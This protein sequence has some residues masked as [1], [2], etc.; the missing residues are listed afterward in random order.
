MGTTPKGLPYPDPDGLVNDVDLVLRQLAEAVDGKLTGLVRAAGGRR[1]VSVS[2]ANT[3]YSATVNFPAGRFTAPPAVTVTPEI[4]G[5]LDST[6]AA[7]SAVTA[8]GFTLRWR[9]SVTT[10]F[11][12]AW[13][14]VAVG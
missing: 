14:A 10:D 9:R 7:V 8:D 13:T 11:D 4:T 5:Y 12:V 3:N 2:A 1:T 6:Y